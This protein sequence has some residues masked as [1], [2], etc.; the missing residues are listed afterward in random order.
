MLQLEDIETWKRWNSFVSGLVAR[1]CPWWIHLA[2][3][4][5]SDGLETISHDKATEFDVGTVFECKLWVATE[6]LIRSGGVLWQDLN[7]D[8]E[9]LDEELRSIKPG[10]LCS[11]VYPCSA[12]RWDF[13]LSR[14]KELA[15]KKSTTILKDG[16]PHDV[17][18][19]LSSLSRL[20]EAITAM[21]KWRS[22]AEAKG[23]SS[24]N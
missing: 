14:L 12:Q 6:W 24:G 11:D 19:S 5:V 21:Y 15:E 18:L 3:C 20:E 9:L 22:S 4:E 1:G 2:Y 7:S 13:W 10:P 16:T 8:Q 23:Q 17:A